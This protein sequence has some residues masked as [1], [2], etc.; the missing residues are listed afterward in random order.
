MTRT[1][2]RHGKRPTPPDDVLAPQ[3]GETS[4]PSRHDHHARSA[5]A[6][7]G[8]GQ[9]EPHHGFGDRNG[10]E[11]DRPASSDDTPT[12]DA[13]ASYQSGGTRQARAQQD[14]ERKQRA[15]GAGVGH[16]PQG[17]ADPAPGAPATR[18]GPDRV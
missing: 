2:D 4:T 15:G 5:D 13:G 6:R 3:P 1:N 10:N 18:D 9:K 14:E 11:V 8:T 12:P 7:S 16:S 17:G